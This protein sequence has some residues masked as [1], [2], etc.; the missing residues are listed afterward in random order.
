MRKRPVANALYVVAFVF[1]A[2]AASLASPADMIVFLLGF[3]APSLLAVQLALLTASVVTVAAA[4]WLD[5]RRTPGIA[6]AMG[7]VAVA[8]H[9]AWRELGAYRRETVAFEAGPNRFGG[10][11]YIPRGSVGPRPAVL[12]LHGSGPVS[13]GA[14]HFLADRL[15][16]GGRIVLNVDKRGV[17]KS[18]GRYYGDNT[19]QRTPLEQRADDAAAALA[20]LRRD[21]RVDA[22][23][24]GVFAISQGGWVFPL[25]AKR[26]SLRFAVMMSGP[27]VSTGEEE[28]FSEL[29]NEQADHFG[30]RPPPI[31]FPE[32]DRRMRSTAPAGYDPRGDLAHVA[33]PTLWLFGDW[34]TSLPV[35]ASVRVLDTLRAAGAR[36]T[37]RR[38]A[39]SNHGLFVVRGPNGRRLARFA[40]GVWDT[41][42]AW[43]DRYA[44][45]DRTARAQPTGAR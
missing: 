38:F 32:L 1:L 15:A 40:P 2:L 11:M 33:T 17:G 16:R 5:R 31:P 44:A 45:N 7:L 20:F 21:K 27:A 26:D 4:L 23:V 12:V 36:F 8:A 10:T 25:L 37:I 41:V 29:T 28:T 39:E 3:I 35:D 19:G 22:N 14:Y 6:F 30:R 9:A 42:S 34:D 18:S 24:V 13:R 43:L